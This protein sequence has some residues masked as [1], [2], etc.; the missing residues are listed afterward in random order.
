MRL[1]C[2]E[3]LELNFCRGHIM[4]RSIRVYLR[5]VLCL[6]EKRA[7]GASINTKLVIWLC[8]VGVITGC[9]MSIACS[10][11]GPVLSEPQLDKVV[12]MAGYKPQANLPF[13]AVYV[14]QENGYFDQ[15]NIAV[16][17]LVVQILQ[18][19]PRRLITPQ[20]ILKD[21]QI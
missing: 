8:V 13:V 16:D 2:K 20:L 18:L 4:L 12:F 5:V 7:V 9:Y 11:H 21:F 19:S 17:I 3:L 15:Q 14:A 1:T 6:F 10:V